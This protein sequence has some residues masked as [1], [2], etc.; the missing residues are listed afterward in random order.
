MLWILNSIF[1]FAFHNSRTECL[2]LN[3]AYIPWTLY[4]IFF[5]L[6]Q[7]VVFWNSSHHIFR[8]ISWQQNEKYII[9]IVWEKL[10]KSAASIQNSRR[11]YNTLFHQLLCTSA[12]IS[13]SIRYPSTGC[14]SLSMKDDS[15][16]LACLFFHSSQSEASRVQ[17]T[18]QVKRQRKQKLRSVPPGNM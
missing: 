15:A 8:K 9:Y 14:P 11:F 12:I 18:R 6:L 16:L 4:F 3:N 1:S 10:D 7:S 2:I 13:V 17:P 5:N